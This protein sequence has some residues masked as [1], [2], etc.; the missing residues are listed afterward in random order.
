M[1]AGRDEVL[2]ALR[3]AL[4]GV[5]LR[6][7]AAA[8]GLLTGRQHLGTRETVSPKHRDYRES[9]HQR[10]GEFPH[11]ALVYPQ[12]GGLRNRYSDILS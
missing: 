6:L 4:G 11:Q 8:M 3:M 2:H 10:T 1:R 9:N 7:R 12:S 5:R